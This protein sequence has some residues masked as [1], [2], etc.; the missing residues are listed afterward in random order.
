MGRVALLLALIVSLAAC[1]PAVYRVD[2]RQGFDGAWDAGE[3]ETRVHLETYGDE[4]RLA[5]RGRKFVFKGMP[6]FKGEISEKQ[7][8]L[9]GEGIDIQINDENVIVMHTQGRNLTQ[10]PLANFPP[11]RTAIYVN[12]GW[13]Y[14]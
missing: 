13:T 11:E 7:V 5:F 4:V 1:G 6:A 8:H 3:E 12:E 9:R 2:K 10:I 14:R